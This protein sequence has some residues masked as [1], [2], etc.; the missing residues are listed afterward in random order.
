MKESKQDQKE[1]SRC[2]WIEN[3]LVSNSGNIWRSPILVP[4]FARRPSPLPSVCTVV[5]R[6]T[7][8]LERLNKQGEPFP[9]SSV[10]ESDDSDDDEIEKAKRTDTYKCFRDDII[11]GARPRHVTWKLIKIL[12]DG[13]KVEVPTSTYLTRMSRYEDEDDEGAQMNRVVPDGF[14]TGLHRQKEATG[15][16]FQ[17]ELSGDRPF[18]IR[19][20]RM[21]C[22]SAIAN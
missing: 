10:L 11:R 18:L 2:L 1:Q 12:P 6:F 22:L 16:K 15:T 21:D 3:V 13:K 7:A 17:F 9:A 19:N 8:N 4:S 5:M 14:N 20:F